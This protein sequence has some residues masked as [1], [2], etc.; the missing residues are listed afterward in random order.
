[1]IVSLT[2]K[3]IAKRKLIIEDQIHEEEDFEYCH[4]RYIISIFKL[5][6]Q[7]INEPH[8]QREFRT[9]LE[10]PLH[11]RR[12]VRSDQMLY[13]SLL[14]RYNTLLYLKD[15][16][17]SKVWRERM[18]YSILLNDSPST[19]HNIW[20]YYGAIESLTLAFSVIYKEWTDKDFEQLF[21]LNLND[22]S[23]IIFIVCI[24]QL[25]RNKQYTQCYINFLNG[26]KDV[27]QPN[28]DT[29]LNFLESLVK[30][31]LLLIPSKAL[32]AMKQYFKL[33][34]YN[35]IKCG[36]INCNKNYLK[37]QYN[38]Q[39]SIINPDQ[40]STFAKCN[41]TKYLKQ[42]QQKWVTKRMHNQWK[43]CKNCK[44]V[45]YCSKRCQKISWNE[46]DHRKYC[47]EVKDYT[48]R[49]KQ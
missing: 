5:D 10:N 1:M 27:W 45:K 18:T 16:I 4:P 3:I 40:L 29:P 7:E 28:G 34:S 15:E 26:R 49:F 21:S 9:V 17:D 20:K 23:S 25:F 44:R 32:D 41:V 13:Y 33:L 14:W 2:A 42:I 38:F 35:K 31:I 8:N 37:H 6:G 36:N 30:K 43:I 22:I 47:F 48:K 19:T 11:Y 39:L 46:Q 12:L 24:Y